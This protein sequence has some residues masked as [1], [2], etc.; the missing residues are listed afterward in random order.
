LLA[1]HRDPGLNLV[2]CADLFVAEES[3]EV[4]ASLVAAA[5]QWAASS[6]LSGVIFH[7]FSQVMADT[8]RGPGLLRQRLRRVREYIRVSEGSAIDLSE[9]G[10]YLTHLLGDRF[11]S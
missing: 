6:R 8:L 7:P 11:L 10:C 4:I 2:E 1:R 3:G 9:A 5:A